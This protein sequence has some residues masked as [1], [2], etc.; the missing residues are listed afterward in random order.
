MNAQTNPRAVVGDN[1]PP[2]FEA[3]KAYIEDL[4]E[5]AKNW[6]DGAPIETQEQADAVQTLLRTLQEAEGAAD[7]ERIKEKKP[8][9]EQVEAI[10]ERYAPLIADTK[11]VKGL[12]VRSIAACKQALTTWLRKQEALR[13]AAAEQLRKEAEA[14]EHAAAEALRAAHQATD[15]AAT[16]QA[17]AAVRDAQEA[18]REARRAETARVHATGQGRA[19]G[20][21]DNW[22]ATLV[23]PAAA[24][25][26]YM[27]T[28]PESLK[29]WL[30]E[31]GRQDVR[32]GKRTIPGFEV[33]NE[34]VAV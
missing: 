17:E 28:D 21:R 27:A 32:S 9:D 1:N 4:Y 15:L 24:L 34:P 23:D 16:E 3:I 19:V 11:K 14:R 30:L 12:T 6:C 31:R 18:D 33:V 25:R 22:I 7:A 5:E 13:I 2:P 10:Q 29:G 20:L 8:L 26:H